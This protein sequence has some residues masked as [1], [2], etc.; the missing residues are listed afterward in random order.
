MSTDVI[1]VSPRIIR[2]MLVDSDGDT[3]ARDELLKQSA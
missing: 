3:C 1:G 2:V